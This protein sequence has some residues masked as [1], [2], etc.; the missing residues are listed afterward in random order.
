MSFTIK[1]F[2]ALSEAELD[3]IRSTQLTDGQRYIVKEARKKGSHER[4]FYKAQLLIESG[5]ID[6]EAEMLSLKEM[7]KEDKLAAVVE[8]IE[9]TA[10][11]NCAVKIRSNAIC[12]LC[13]SGLKYKYCCYRKNNPQK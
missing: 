8:K 12:P 13:D 4:N 10:T 7:L 3:I 5:Q 9:R 2:K 6:L 11:A 1:E